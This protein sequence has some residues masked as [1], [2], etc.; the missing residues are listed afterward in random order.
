MKFPVLNEVQSK[1]ESC[2]VQAVVKSFS[3]ALVVA[4]NPLVLELSVMDKIACTTSLDVSLGLCMHPSC[5][6]YR[7]AKVQ[8]LRVLG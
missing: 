5:L 7:R 8:N 1:K 3:D 4:A 6:S 2:V